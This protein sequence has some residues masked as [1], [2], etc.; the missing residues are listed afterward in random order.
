MN[1]PTQPVRTSLTAGPRAKPVGARTVAPVPS[2]ADRRGRFPAQLTHLTLAAM[3]AF[4]VVGAAGQSPE[5][6][7][8]PVSARTTTAPVSR[9]AERSVLLDVLDAGAPTS[10]TVPASAT[11]GQ[12][13]TQAG[14]VLGEWD[15][16]T[17]DPATPV[18]EAGQVV[19]TRVSVSLVTERTVTARP[20][21]EVPDPTRAAGRRTVVADGA[22]GVVDTLVQVGADHTGAQVWRTVVT[23]VV[24][25]E[26][27]EQVI[28]VG[29]AARAAVVA[30]G[31]VEPGS[32]R[33]IAARMVSDRGWGSDQFACLDQLWTRESG[34]RV[35]AANRSSGAYG[36]PQ[37][38]PGSKMASAGADW[39][40]NPATQISWGLGYIAGRYTDPCGA[41]A[42]FGTK[43]WY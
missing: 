15:T 3:L 11:V 6:A 30:V 17:P 12:A 40:T 29:T 8:A 9:S 27:A 34:W 39:Q 36:I 37:A 2:H 10:L 13:L 24:V 35:D 20:V 26:P 43:G 21:R 5:P 4:A 25:S 42:H 7:P 16:L 38:L 19:I 14:V 1:R 33:E 32:A 41:W 22:D 28:S 23:T 18:T 31:P